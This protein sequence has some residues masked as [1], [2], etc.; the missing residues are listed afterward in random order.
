M[1]VKIEQIGN[2]GFARPIAD[3]SIN[4]TSQ[5]FR[6]IAHAV[7]K[8]ILSHNRA[9]QK[10]RERAQFLQLSDHVLSDIG[11]RKMDAM[12]DH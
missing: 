12:I 9:R 8:L 3:V 5:I 4:L 7:A 6:A 2:P 11:A 10:R 1:S